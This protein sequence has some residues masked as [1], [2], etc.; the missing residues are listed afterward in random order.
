MLKPRCTPGKKCPDKW[1][2]QFLPLFSLSLVICDRLLEH[3]IQ[4]ITMYCIL[5]SHHHITATWC[6]FLLIK[7]HQIWYWLPVR[8]HIQYK[9]GVLT[10]KVRTTGAPS[11]LRQHL[12]QHAKHDPRRFHYWQFLEQTPNL[13]TFI[14]ILCTFH[15]EQST[16][17]RLKL[18][19][20]T[21]FQETFEDISF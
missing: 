18:Q 10:R 21:Y 6:Q 9:V 5:L 20:G 3:I 12:V 15:L 11:N 4:F 1:L 13:K 2:N 14:F 17:R 7:I 8:L 19:F 16:R